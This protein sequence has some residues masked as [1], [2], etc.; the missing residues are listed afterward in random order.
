MRNIWYLS[1]TWLPDII[2][3]TFICHHDGWYLSVTITWNTICQ[4][5][6]I[7]FFHYDDTKC[8]LQWPSTHIGSSK[9]LHLLTLYNQRDTQVL[10][11]T[12]P[13]IRWPVPSPP[14]PLL[15]LG[16]IAL[17]SLHPELLL[18][19]PFSTLQTDIVSPF[20]SI[21]KLAMTLYV[22]QIP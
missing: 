22:L 14:F 7:V 3:G 17:D 18:A 20:S 12:F 6:I 2:I 15:L 11:H 19:N 5:V 4:D 10:W 9:S 8:P 21:C 13:D 16:T 1:M